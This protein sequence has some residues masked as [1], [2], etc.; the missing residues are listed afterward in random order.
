MLQILTNVIRHEK[1]ITGIG[2]GNEEVKL[3][4]LREDVIIYLKIQ[5]NPWKNTAIH[6]RI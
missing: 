1:A 3:Y 5:K 6:K 4:L 2:I